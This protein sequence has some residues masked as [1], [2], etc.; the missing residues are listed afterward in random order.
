VVPAGGLR[1]DGLRWRRPQSADFFLPQR[2]LAA[3]FRNRL[4]ATL[5]QKHP[6]QFKQI[7]A[8][9]WRQQWV[10]DVRPVGNGEA[11]VKY[12]SAYVCRTALGNQRILRDEQGNITFKYK[13]SGDGQWRTLSLPAQEFI[14]RFLQHVLPKGFQRVRYYGWLGAAAKQKWQRI[15]ALL[16]W[17]APTLVLPPQA[18]MLCPHCGKLLCWIGTLKPP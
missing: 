7:P 18:P 14:R 12:L 10:V 4:K 2:V 16:D 1:E 13:T 5:A 11:A 6:L 9:I 3:R 8:A 17:K 15:L